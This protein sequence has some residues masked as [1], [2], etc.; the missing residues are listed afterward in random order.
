MQM[1]QNIKFILLKLLDIVYIK[2]LL[3]HWGNSI[4]W[5]LI[6]I[7]PS[8]TKKKKEHKIL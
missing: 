8:P 1:D 6:S 7:A 5:T 3:S 2:Y 4:W